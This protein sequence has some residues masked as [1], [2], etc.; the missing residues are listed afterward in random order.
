MR[1]AGHEP[2]LTE[3]EAADETELRVSHQKPEATG[4]E[5]SAANFKL[6]YRGSAGNELPRHVFPDTGG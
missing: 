2:T 1:E 4:A 3:A 6:C 5:P